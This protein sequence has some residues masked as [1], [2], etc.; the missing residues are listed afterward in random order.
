MYVAPRQGEIPKERRP[1]ADIASQE[2]LVV[3]SPI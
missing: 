2:H 3:D 1:L